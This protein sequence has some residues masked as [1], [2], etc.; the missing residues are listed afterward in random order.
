[1]ENR[2]TIGRV[3]DFPAAPQPHPR[4][5]GEAIDQL[6]RELAQQRRE[7][8]GLVRQLETIREGRDDL[9]G[10]VASL[11]RRIEAVEA[12]GGKAENLERRDSERITALA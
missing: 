6:R 11:R 10:A 1:M 2:Q 8:D 7:I 3:Q 9:L 4:S 5:P 12:D